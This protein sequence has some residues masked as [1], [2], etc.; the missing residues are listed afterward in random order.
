MTKTLPSAPPDDWRL[1]SPDAAADLLTLDPQLAQLIANVEAADSPLE[2]RDALTALL[3][4]DNPAAGLR[5]LELEGSL[6]R[7]LPEIAALRGVSQLPDHVMDALDHT[8]MVVDGAPPTPLSRW[9]ALFHDSGKT[10]TG[11]TTATGRRRFFGHEIVG[12]N[13]ARAALPR[14]ALSAPFIAQVAR[15]IEL[16]LRPLAYR[17]EW[18]DAA[19]RRLLDE[20]GTL[21]PALLDQA[22]A[23][24]IGYQPEPIERGLRNLDQLEERAL[25][26]QAPPPPA[27]PGSPLDGNELQAIF[28]RPP[29]PWLRRIKTL[30]DTAVQSG[31]LA[32]DDKT[33]AVQLAAQALEADDAADEG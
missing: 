30:L 29:G 24:L 19:V 22:R 17:E 4:S 20:A 11:L 23:D 1:V 26:V 6:A 10:V 8:L 25:L 16:H 28:A 33:G 5:L 27:P 12:A 2:R 21:W 13:L 31:T 18:T 32:P 7:L 9:T 14:F 15:L 3:V